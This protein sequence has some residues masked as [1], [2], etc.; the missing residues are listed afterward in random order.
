ME[1][2]NPTLF[3]PLAADNEFIKNLRE[4]LKQSYLTGMANLNNQRYLD[5]SALMNQANKAGV[6]F[7]NFPQRA[8]IQYDT[9]TYMPNQVKLRQGYQ[10]GLDTIRE[11]AIN[12]ANQV[13]YYQ[14]MI[15]HYNTLPT[16]SSSSTSVNEISNAVAQS[17][18]NNEEI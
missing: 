8:K 5:H 14:Q 12:A 11:N 17:L 2:Y 9:N 6:M 15:D 3:D 7:S 16:N 4:S 10:T 18:K 13:R 1:S